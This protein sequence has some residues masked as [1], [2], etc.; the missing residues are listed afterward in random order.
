VIRRRIGDQ[1]VVRRDAVWWAIADLRER[2]KGFRERRAELDRALEV[3]NQDEMRAIRTAIGAEAESLTKRLGASLKAAGGAAVTSVA[4]DPVAHLSA[5][6]L[7]W[8][9]TG[10]SAVIAGARKLLPAEVTHRLVWRLCRPEL[11]F[12]SDVTMDS[13]AVIDSLP[14]VRRLWGLADAEVD[15]FA[16]RIEG[17]RNGN[18]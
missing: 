11:R 3:G 13:R 18:K 17:F 12:M 6:P 7:D 16:Q 15:R 14:N 5:D 4:A 8:L 10:L 9:R 2:A 1:I